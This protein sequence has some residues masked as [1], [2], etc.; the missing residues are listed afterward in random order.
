M[1]QMPALIENVMHDTHVY[2][3]EVP[4]IVLGNPRGLLI[5]GLV[6]STCGGGI[7]MPYDGFSMAGIGNLDPLQP[8]V[9]KYAPALL[10]RAG[11][12]HQY[13]LLYLGFQQ[14]L[15]LIRHHIDQ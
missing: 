9:Q 14:H 15:D 1:N 12:T 6:N 11:F 5:K 8:R 13:L 3:L 10:V 2:I 4:D 7:V